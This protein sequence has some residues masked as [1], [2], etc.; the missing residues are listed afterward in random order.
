MTKR[1]RLAGGGVRSRSSPVEGARLNNAPTQLLKVPPAPAPAASAREAP[2]D[3]ER[4]ASQAIVA[5]PELPAKVEALLS[6]ETRCNALVPPVAPPDDFDDDLS[7]ADL[8][9]LPAKAKLRSVPATA[10]APAPAS[11]AVA[12]PKRRPAPEPARLQ[13]SSMYDDSTVWAAGIPMVKRFDKK[14]PTFYV[15]CRAH[16]GGR[17]ACTKSMQIN[18]PDEQT[19][20]KRL[21]WWLLSGYTMVKDSGPVGQWDGVYPARLCLFQTKAPRDALSAIGCQS[22]LHGA[23]AFADVRVAGE[24]AEDARR[25]HMALEPPVTEAELDDVDFDALLEQQIALRGGS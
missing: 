16:Q 5:E 4:A 25:R 11:A 20:I 14:I 2:A 15:H 22:T 7:M 12:G 6:N 9:L 24:S 13:A 10:A 1:S 8:L 17:R 23:C 21:K 3:T 18:R 19:V